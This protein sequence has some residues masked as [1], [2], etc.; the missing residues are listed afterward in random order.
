MAASKLEQDMVTWR[1]LAQYKQERINLKI[2]ERALNNAHMALRIREGQEVIRP[3]VAA[4]SLDDP[5]AS[6]YAT[7]AGAAYRFA[8]GIMR[9]LGCRVERKSKTEKIWL[10]SFHTIFMEVHVAGAD[11]K[12]VE[13]RLG[14]TRSELEEVSER[15]RALVAR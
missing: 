8:A 3:V 4:Y 12:A 14:Q 5:N 9:I 10:M 7:Q 11:L 13:R 2:A 15:Q 1:E 6:R